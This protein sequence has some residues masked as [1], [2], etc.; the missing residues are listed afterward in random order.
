L[1]AI[2]RKI[3]PQPARPVS[4]RERQASVRQPARA[5]SREADPGSREENALKQKSIAFS[6]FHETQKCNSAAAMSLKRGVDPF[7]FWRLSIPS[8]NREGQWYRDAL[9][10][11]RER[12]LFANKKRAET[13]AP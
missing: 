13:G 1:D 2:K 6:C 7:A 3:T 10:L 11:P 9:G 12:V 5:F 8:P 4:R